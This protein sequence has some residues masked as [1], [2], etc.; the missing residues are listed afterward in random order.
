[1]TLSAQR[2]ADDRAAART[3]AI[4]SDMSGMQARK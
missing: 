3:F 4:S 1:M 2:P